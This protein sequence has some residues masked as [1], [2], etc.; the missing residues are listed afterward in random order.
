MRLNK[1]F[2]L[3]N[4]FIIIYLLNNLVYTINQF[5]GLM[6]KVKIKMTATSNRPTESK[7]KQDQYKKKNEVIKSNLTTQLTQKKCIKNLVDNNRT[8]IKDIINKM[9]EKWRDVAMGTIYHW[10]IIIRIT[11]IIIIMILFVRTWSIS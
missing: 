11:I 10:P 4:E 8:R 5:A 2:I 3:T 7:I 1:P 9:I 6:V